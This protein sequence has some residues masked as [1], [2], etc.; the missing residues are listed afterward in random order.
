MIVIV[1][2]VIVI[3]MTE[4]K[5]DLEG[6]MKDIPTEGDRLVKPVEKIVK[7]PVKQD[8]P[9]LEKRGLYLP[10]GRLSGIAG[11]ITVGGII[12]AGVITL[13]NFLNTW[14]KDVSQINQNSTSETSSL[15]P[16]ASPTQALLPTNIPTTNPTNT[17]ITYKQWDEYG[18]IDSRQIKIDLDKGDLLLLSAGVLDVEDYKCYSVDGQLCIYIREAQRDET[19]AIT[20][21]VQGHVWMGISE[22]FT[23]EEAIE[24]GESYYWK[25]PNC[26]EGCDWARIYIERENGSIDHYLL[27]PNGHTT[28]ME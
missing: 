2:E 24:S 16:T 5:P 17:P 27:Y 1:I 4:E 7:A 28:D 9:P 18:V 26:G 25:S 11:I 22:E 12:I 21:I 8:I 13:S 20:N 15:P 3:K 19:V 14:T 6:M 23:P 10:P